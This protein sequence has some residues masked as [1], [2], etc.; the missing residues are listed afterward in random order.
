[1]LSVFFRSVVSG[2]RDYRGLPKLAIPATYFPKKITTAFLRDSFDPAS[3]GIKRKIKKVPGVAVYMGKNIRGNPVFVD[4]RG[5]KVSVLE[6]AIDLTAFIKAFPG[7]CLK[8]RRKRIKVSSLPPDAVFK[9][10]AI[11]G[12]LHFG[13]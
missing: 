9:G 5:H 12:G 6:A 10:R 2:Q 8:R 7:S 1:M 13:K 3:K 4:P 11:G